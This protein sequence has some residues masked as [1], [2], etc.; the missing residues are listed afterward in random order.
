M[1]DNNSAQIISYDALRS[2]SIFPN[3]IIVLDILV[4]VDVW[5]S[6]AIIPVNGK[7]YDVYAKRERR[8]D[9]VLADT[10]TV[11]YS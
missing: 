5:Y 6:T 9:G 2:E 8:D 11:E 7:D 10:S 3:G 1:S 4:G